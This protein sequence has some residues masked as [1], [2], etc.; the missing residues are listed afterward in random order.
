M[1]QGADQVPLLDKQDDVS[2]SRCDPAPSLFVEFLKFLR[3]VR[4]VLRRRAIFDPP[5]A[6][7]LD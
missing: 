1:I 6:L 3:A 4:L 5:P 2:E 7:Y